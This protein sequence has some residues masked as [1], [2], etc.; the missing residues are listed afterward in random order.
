MGV[1]VGQYAQQAGAGQGMSH[2]LAAE[3][4]HSIVEDLASKGG[5]VWPALEIGSL[6][7]LDKERR[8]LLHVA[9]R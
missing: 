4:V 8:H 1:D 9:E 6:K 5:G 3:L 2:G 7:E